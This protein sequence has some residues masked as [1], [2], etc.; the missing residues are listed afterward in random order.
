M[1]HPPSLR[2]TLHGS[3]RL[4]SGLRQNELWRRLR[5]DVVAKYLLGRWWRCCWHTYRVQKDW[6]PLLVLRPNWCS[7][8]DVLEASRDL[9]R[10]N[11]WRENKIKTGWRGVSSTCVKH[12][13]S[14]WEESMVPHFLCSTKNPLTLP[15]IL[16]TDQNY[17]STLSEG[18]SHK[19]IFP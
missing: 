1:L 4:Q 10:E 14:M 17:R 15:K 13:L 5:Q 11:V 8:V 7:V 19:P 3:P 6:R 9:N 12:T 16:Y 2:L 18:H